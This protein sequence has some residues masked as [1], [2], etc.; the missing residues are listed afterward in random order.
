[1]Y[2]YLST[3]SVQFVLILLGLLVRIVF[4]WSIGGVTIRKDLV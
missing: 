1:M 4:V 3:G 2:L